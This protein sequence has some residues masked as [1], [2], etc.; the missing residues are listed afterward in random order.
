M[1][2]KRAN[3]LHSVSMY[4]YFHFSFCCFGSE[5]KGGLRHFY[6]KGIKVH[7]K[8]LFGLKFVNTKMQF[9]LKHA[10]LD[11]LHVQV[12]LYTKTPTRFKLKT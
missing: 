7:Q 3:K 10:N 12:Q 4:L 2:V 9:L 8:V 1:S 11:F 5:N 6:T